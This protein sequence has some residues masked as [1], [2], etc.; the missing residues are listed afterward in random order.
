MKQKTV[1]LYPVLNL[2]WLIGFQTYGL[3]PKHLPV[4]TN[5]TYIEKHCCYP[6]ACSEAL[7]WLW[8]SSLKQ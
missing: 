5:W 4:V 8:I 3:K 2:W 7:K 6:V 1:I